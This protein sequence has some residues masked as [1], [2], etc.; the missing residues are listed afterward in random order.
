MR[1]G[2]RGRVWR[3]RLARLLAAVVVLG[4]VLL[5]ATRTGRYLVRAAWEEGKILWH[6]RPIAALVADPATDA[7][8]RAKLRLVL[9]AR[10]FA[11]DS[12]RLDAGESFT[13]YTALER[14]TLVVLVSAAARDR[15][16]VHTWWFPVVGRVPY[17]G[18]FDVADARD[19]ARRLE[20]RGYDTYLRPSSAFS[21]LGWFNDPL[22]S[23]SLRADS[24]SLVDTVIHELLHNTFYA[25]GEAI[26]NE[27]FANFVG[28]RGAEWFFRSRGD[29]A[30]A[31]EVARRWRDERRL[32]AF[33][34]RVYRT[35]DSAFAAHPGDDDVARRARLAARDTVYARMRT[36]L[37]TEVGP[38]LET[39][40]PRLLRYTQ[41]NNA[42]LLARRIYLT[43]LELFEAVYAREGCDLR[44]A[45]AR[46][47]ALVEAHEDEDPYEALRGWLHAPVTTTS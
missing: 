32:G 20:A 21:T 10:A 27:S 3:R 36:V 14:D 11:V 47:T 25:P 46:I 38:Q 4:V 37:L 17:K 16:R 30:S 15:L 28:A 35:L 5:A 34:T 1:G 19:E 8:T 7:A 39:I 41:F 13:R 6:R 26:F 9:Q 33:W 29:S 45:I 44:R 31:R 2:G 42:L 22:L 18:F 23:T 43:D 24:L 12:V 40:D